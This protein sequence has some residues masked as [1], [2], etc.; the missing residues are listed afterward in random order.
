M[1]KAMGQGFCPLLRCLGMEE[2]VSP[3]PV[4]E[5]LRGQRV[6]LNADGGR[7]RLRRNKKGKPKANGR[8]GYYGEWKE[9]KLFTLYAMD[10]EGKRINTIEVPI[11]NDGTFAGV[12]VF[13]TLL[14]MYF[15]KLGVVH[16]N[17]VLLVANGAPWIWKRIPS[18]LKRLG[19][20]SEQIIEVINFYHATEKLCEFSELA[21][22]NKKQAKEWFEK[23]R[24]LSKRLD[25][26]NYA[27]TVTSCHF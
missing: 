6:G 9:P 2:R 16:A 8:R 26:R 21:F 15:I 19:L 24:I 17:Q 18:L 23:A 14:E 12:E 27:K 25:F 7:T 20:E 4:G 5:T 1:K 22:S 11:T 13:M 3:L 10:D